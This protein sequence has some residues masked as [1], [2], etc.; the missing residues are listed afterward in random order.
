MTKSRKQK[1]KKQDFLRKKLKVGKPKERASNATDTSFVSKT[2]SIR[3]QHLDHDPHDLTKRLTLLKHHNINVRKET[4]ITFQK[5]IPSIIN[6]RL[7]TPLLTQ[8][9]PL[10]CDESKQVRQGLVDLID[11]IGSHDAQILKLHCNIFV[12]YI[13]MAMTHIVSQIQADSTKFLFHLLKYCSDEVVRKSW[14]K[15]LNGIFGVLGWGQ[16]GKN[17]SASVVQTKKRNA[18][19]VAVHLNALYTLVEYGCQDERARGVDNNTTES[20]VESS[21]FRNPYLIPDYPQPFE[22]LKIFTREL[23]VKDATTKG[24]NATLLSLT[25]QDI[26]TRRASFSEQYLPIVRKQVEIIIKEGGECGKSANNLK[27]LL[28]KVFD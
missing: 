28:A 17:D 14:V 20:L 1:Q 12:L 4:L 11:E 19:Y 13:S 23:K 21:E 25:T 26:E 24:T 5:S 3:N 18:K 8:S 27:K 6:S 10:I 7:M 2:I 15:L 9:I 16:I 22:H